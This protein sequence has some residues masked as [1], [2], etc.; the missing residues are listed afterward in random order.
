MVQVL[1]TRSGE[2]ESTPIASKT[3]PASSRTSTSQDLVSKT[4]CV[5]EVRQRQVT[6]LHP[7]VT[8]RKGK[9]CFS[10]VRV[11]RS[12]EDKDCI[13]TN[14]SSTSPPRGLVEW[15]A[16]NSWST[17]QNK[18]FLFNYCLFVLFCFVFLFVFF[19]CFFFSVSKSSL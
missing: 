6:I 9:G 18:N 19:Y 5:V 3:S 17:N 11:T 16:H 1:A 4:V 7:V 14:S 13:S 8:R 2:W 10:R 12:K 15:Q